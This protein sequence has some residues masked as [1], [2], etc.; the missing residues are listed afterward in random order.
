MKDFRRLFAGV[1]VLMV[2]LLVG[3]NI[4]LLSFFRDESGRPY[5]VEISRLAKEIEEN[6]LE[7]VDLSEC[8]Y[9]TDVKKY[10]MDTTDS[11]YVIQEIEGVPY[12][13]DYTTAGTEYKK[14][15]GIVNLIFGVMAVMVIGVLFFVR[16][17]ILKPFEAIRDVPYELSRG[18]LTVPMK[19]SK[20]R[21]FGKFIWGVDLLREHLEEQKQRELALQKENRTL[22][23]SISHDIKTPLSAIKLY[24]KALSKGLYVKDGEEKQKEIAERIS[25]KADEIEGFVSQIIKASSEDFLNLE[26]ESGEFYLS[27]LI[28]QIVGYY[29][30]KLSFLKIE[31]SVGEY[32]DCILKGDLDR[33]IEVL[34]NLVEN[35]VKYGDGHGIEV[36]FSEEEDC[37]LI[38]V[39]SGG[40]TLSESELPHIFDSF[41]RGSNV[42]SNSGS[43]LGLYICRQL[44]RKM[45]G[46]VFAE[47]RDREMWVTVVFQKV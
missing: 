40:C 24:A 10:V 3:A 18:N 2:L 32:A 30:E 8:Q 41:W 29:S 27:D 9:V 44:M 11:D 12:R 46:E 13:F 28:R 45:D 33:S 4:L 6:G 22:V 36:V 31:F 38:T 16:H 26:V 17:K 42:G 23:L 34:Q 39:R 7:N 37:Q 14:I 15:I 19:E 25:E 47:V 5:R 21:F 35:A 43:G 20:S 1:I